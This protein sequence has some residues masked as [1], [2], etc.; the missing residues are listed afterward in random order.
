MNTRSRQAEN[1][2]ALRPDDRRADRQSIDE[3]MGFYLTGA[4]APPP[5]PLWV[6]VPGAGV[7]APPPE[8]CSC[9]EPGVTRIRTYMTTGFSPGT[10]TTLTCWPTCRL[11]HVTV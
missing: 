7:P 9:V 11:P 5:P 10:K 2:N 3:T 8:P 4:P 6:S 1:E